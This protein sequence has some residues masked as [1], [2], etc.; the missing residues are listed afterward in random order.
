MGIRKLCAVGSLA[1]I[2]CFGTSTLAVK[3]SHGHGW[4]WPKLS[5][6][7]H[8]ASSKLSEA[9]V[10]FHKL[11]D[12][13]MK[14]MSGGG[15]GVAGIKGAITTKFSSLFGGNMEEMEQSGGGGWG[16]TQM[17]PVQMMM[18]IEMSSSGGWGQ[19]APAPMETGGWGM[20]MPAASSMPMSMG[21]GGGGGAAMSSGGKGGGGG[22]AAKPTGWASQGGSMMGMQMMQMQMQEPTG[23]ATGDFG[24]FRPMK[25][26]GNQKG[27][28]N[29]ELPQG[30][31]A[32]IQKLKPLIDLPKLSLKGWGW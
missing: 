6:R 18:P 12:G 2:L 13:A 29:F 19:P 1:L 14:G 4:G 28:F 7:H 23:W 22:G 17:A 26:S 11:G 10:K 27:H 3:K 15:G 31:P 25:G 5:T 32:Y 20:M 24:K 21:W 16:A 9:Y 30:K 8:D